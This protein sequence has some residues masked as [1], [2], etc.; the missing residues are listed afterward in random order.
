MLGFFALW[1]LVLVLT[2]WALIDVVKVRT[3][4]SSERARRWCGFY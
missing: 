2:I 3:T 1:V 4:P